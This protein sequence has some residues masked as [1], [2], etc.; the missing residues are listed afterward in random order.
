MNSSFLSLSSSCAAGL[1][2][3][4]VLPA[5]FIGGRENLCMGSAPVSVYSRERAFPRDCLSL[6]TG[7][8]FDTSVQG[9][10]CHRR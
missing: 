2:P 3:S 6:N 10:D 5:T 1:S 7:A 4:A 8:G 9:L